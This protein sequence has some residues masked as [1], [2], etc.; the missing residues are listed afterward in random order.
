MNNSSTS[1]RPRFVCRVVR[2]R[3]PEP[4]ANDSWASR[5]RAGCADCAAHFAGHQTLE[6]EL[7]NSAPRSSEAVPAGLEDRIWAA[8]KSDQSALRQSSQSRSILTGWRTGLA[9]A[10]FAVVAAFLV[11]SQ[12]PTQ[13]TDTAMVRAD[14]DEKDMRELVTKIGDLSAEWLVVAET[15]VTVQTT[16]PLSE[17]LNALEADASAALQFLQRS[18]MPTSKSAS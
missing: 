16:G 2:W 15:D 1:S 10:S 9:L 13:S 7:R 4:G 6:H 3:H 8:V 5:H 14:F 17:E 11:W 18:F 12:S